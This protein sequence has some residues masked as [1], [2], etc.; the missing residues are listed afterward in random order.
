MTITATAVARTD[1]G[2]V[3]KNNQDNCLVHAL[4]RGGTHYALWVVA[5]GMGGG[6]RGEVASELAITT[7]RDHMESS[8]WTEPEAALRAAFSR[9]NSRVFD[10]GSGFGEST[11]SAMGTTLVAVLVDENSGNAWFA[12]VGDSRAYVISNGQMEQVSADH[13]VVGA[14]VAAGRIT[15]DEARTAKERN[16]ITRSIG[17][18][19]SVDIDVFAGPIAPGE[20]VLLCSDGLHGMLTDDEIQDI[21]VTNQLAAAV[22]QLV[23]LA[24]ERGGQDNITVIIGEATSTTGEPVR[25]LPRGRWKQNR[26]ALAAAAA[27]AYAD[28]TISMQIPRRW[29]QRREVLAL[30]G[31]GAVLVLFLGAFLL[32]KAFGGGGGTEEGTPTASVAT[33]T[34]AT[35]TGTAEPTTSPETPSVAATTPYPTVGKVSFE[36]GFYRVFLVEDTT[37]PTTCDNVISESGGKSFALIQGANPSIELLRDGNPCGNLQPGLICLDQVER[38]TRGGDPPCVG[39]VRTSQGIVIVWGHSRDKPLTI[40][41]VVAAVQ[42]PTAVLQPITV[43]ARADGR[44]CIVKYGAGVN[45][46]NP[47]RDVLLTVGTISFN[48]PTGPSAANA[49]PAAECLP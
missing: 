33:D 17:M 32:S 39:A 1:V 49:I 37:P 14:L 45:A 23:D 2:M 34:S 19:R 30:A 5:D 16:V 38:D 29:H 7:V 6:A 40:R 12:N 42:T 26:T 10:E 22:T 13:S 24:N 9:A 4:E 47:G 43:D 44:F 3:R 25:V 8:P 31:V 18:D 21:A 36:S 20:R 35:A 27:A 28:T 11:R 48:I 41:L 15:A 46:L